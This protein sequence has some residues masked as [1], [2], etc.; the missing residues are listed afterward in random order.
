MSRHQPTPETQNGGSRAGSSCISSSILNRVEILAFP[1]SVDVG[2][3]CADL[4]DPG[5]LGVGFGI[6]T[7]SSIE[8]EIQL[9]GLLRAVAPRYRYCS[10][11]TFTV[12]VA[13]APLLLVEKNGDGSA[14]TFSP[15]FW[16]YALPLLLS[17][18]N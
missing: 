9:P 14:A 16:R 4:I 3:K 7:L 15:V 13:V 6:S 2:G 8:R 17:T 12:A 5:N 18:D 1:V 10:G 11:A